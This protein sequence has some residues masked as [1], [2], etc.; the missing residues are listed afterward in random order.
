MRKSIAK[1][2]FWC[3]LGVLTVVCSAYAKL[4]LEAAPERSAG[5]EMGSVKVLNRAVVVVETA[6]FLGKRQ[7]NEPATL[8]VLTGSGLMAVSVRVMRKCRIRLR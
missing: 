8:A 5:E 2:I 4:P 7:G 1:V 6:S 3:F